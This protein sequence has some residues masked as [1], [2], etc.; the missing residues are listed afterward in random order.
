LFFIC[1]AGA[2]SR[3]RNAFQQQEGAAE[4]QPKRPTPRLVVKLVMR[5]MLAPTKGSGC[6]NFSLANRSCQHAR[7]LTQ[8]PALCAAAANAQIEAAAVSMETWLHLRRDFARGQS[9]ELVCHGFPPTICGL[10]GGFSRPSAILNRPPNPTKFPVSICGIIAN[11]GGCAQM[12]SRKKRRKI[13]P[14]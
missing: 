4:A 12:R 2:L 13:R 5:T 14:F 11:R 3:G 9:V 7:V 6:G 10:G 8:T 1:A